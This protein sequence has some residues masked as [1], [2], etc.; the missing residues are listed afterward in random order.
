MSF[1]DNIGLAALLE[2]RQEAWDN[3]VPR[4]PPP[5]PILVCTSHIHWDPEFCDVKLVQTM[6]LMHELRLIA[7]S[8]A[9]NIIP[10]R[11]SSPNDKVNLL[12]CGDFNSLPDSGSSQPLQSLTLTLYTF[13]DVCRYV[14]INYLYPL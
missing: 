4:D 10:S 12:L 13:D 3:G 9:T 1:L 5:L 8:V 7:D 6:M 14:F 2:T 11:H